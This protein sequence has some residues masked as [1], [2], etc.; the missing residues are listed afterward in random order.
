M[1]L[2]AVGNSCI[3]EMRNEGSYVNF[4]QRPRDVLKGL[5]SYIRLDR[6]EK[7]RQENGE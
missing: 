6:S 4:N 1:L 2:T 7:E 3:R 5:S